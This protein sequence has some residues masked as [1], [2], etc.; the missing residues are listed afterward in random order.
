MMFDNYVIVCT[1]FSGL[2]CENNIDE[3]MHINC[4]E[5]RVCIDLVAGYECRCPDGFTGDNCSLPIDPCAKTFCQ[6]GG[7]CKVNQL[8]HGFTCACQNGFTGTLQLYHTINL[9]L[10]IINYRRTIL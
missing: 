9:Y 2:T 7:T 8:T 4:P 5:G 1:G 10:L 3:C 6:N